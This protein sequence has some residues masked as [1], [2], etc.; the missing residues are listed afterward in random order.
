VAGFE[1]T[2]DNANPRFNW[3]GL[4][5]TVTVARL[6][7]RELTLQNKR[8]DTIKQGSLYQVAGNHVPATVGDEPAAR[9]GRGD[10]RPGAVHC[11]ELLGGL[12]KSYRS[13]A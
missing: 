11:D 1:V 9:T 7:C 13:A 3:A 10:Q 5:L 12:L 2:R 8:S 6:L 4:P